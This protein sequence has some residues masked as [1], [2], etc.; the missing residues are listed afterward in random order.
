MRVS[1]E[2]PRWLPGPF[3]PPHPLS[4]SRA[5][6]LPRASPPTTPDAHL[7][8]FGKLFFGMEGPIGGGAD[9]DEEG[10][11]LEDDAA[12]DEE[13][14]DG[15]EGGPGGGGGLG[16]MEAMIEQVQQLRTAV[17]SGE[18]EA[19]SAGTM[20]RL[21]HSFTEAAAPFALKVRG[22][23]RQVARALDGGG[24][25]DVNAPGDAGRTPL[26]LAAASGQVLIIRRLLEVCTS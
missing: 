22:G 12:E 17:Q 4:L 7:N 11:V 25:F 16:M 6:A 3:P 20:Q 10:A 9:G 18:L 5:V 26:H 19:V 23:P 21:C 15:E 14:D 13:E 24:G 1:G 8:R 2:V